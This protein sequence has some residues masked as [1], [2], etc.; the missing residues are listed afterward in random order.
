MNSYTMYTSVQVLQL[1]PSHQSLLTTLG[2]HGL[3]VTVGL[4]WGIF[5]MI[6]IAKRGSKLSNSEQDICL[7]TLLALPRCCMDFHLQF[8]LLERNDVIYG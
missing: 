7:L 1:V 5:I 2:T 6:Q 4:F 8:H 3:H